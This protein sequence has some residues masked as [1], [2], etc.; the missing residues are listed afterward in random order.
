MPSDKQ[1]AA[2]RRNATRSTGPRTP[3]GKRAVRHNA[4]KHGILSTD[5]VASRHDESPKEFDALLARLKRE[6]AP[7]G[8]LEEMLVGQIAVQH[9]R[10]R[11]IVRA[12]AG[13][14]GRAASGDPDTN[15]VEKELSILD[16]LDP[17]YSIYDVT[18]ARGARERLSATLPGARALLDLLDA[19]RSRF[20]TPESL[21]PR[22]AN[23]IALLF[24]P[25]ID[26]AISLGWP[27][28]PVKPNATEGHYLTTALSHSTVKPR[29]QRAFDSLHA[30]YQAS[31]P[32]LQQRNAA[33]ATSVAAAHSLPDAPA[34]DK[35][36]RYEKSVQKG[37]FRAMYELT[38][39][40]QLRMAGDTFFPNKP[41]SPND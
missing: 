23:R 5:V 10:L 16:M 2:N 14:I 21:P 13:E 8:F 36:L 6:L 18:I 1:L 3:A 27:R 31:L 9:W 34:A 25:E 15:T 35:I 11:R 38:R 32:A 29:V 17:P 12:E 37:L 40:Q 19:V 7:V 20:D 22:V 33:A 24:T 4:V 41:N 39:L 28:D 30:S 26:D